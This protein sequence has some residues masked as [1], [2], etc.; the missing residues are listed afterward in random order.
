MEEG[1]VDDD[2]VVGAKGETL[3]KSEKMKNAD[4]GEKI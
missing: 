3:A 1:Y 4:G 2:E